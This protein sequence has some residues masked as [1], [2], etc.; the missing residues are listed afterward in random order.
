MNNKIAIILSIGLILAS[1]VFGIFF[2]NA[3]ADD[4]TVSVVGYATR[5]FECDL[6]KWEFQLNQNVGKNEYEKGLQLINE[7]LN[8]F[9]NF[10]NNSNIAVKDLNVQPVNNRPEYEDGKITGR[11]IFQQVTLLSENL[12]E[13]ENLAVNPAYLSEKGINISN[14]RLKY[15]KQGLDKLKEDLLSRAGAN[16]KARAQKI[17]ESTDLKIK[18]MLSANSGVFQITE[19]YST[20]VAGYGIHNTSSRKK[21]IKVTVRASFKVK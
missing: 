6:V 17:L 21:T 14:S 11:R 2:L 5:D 3:R 15:F 10:I 1:T 12:D 20:R 7:N 4:Q 19:R 13:I 8:A 18:K 16:A 9:K